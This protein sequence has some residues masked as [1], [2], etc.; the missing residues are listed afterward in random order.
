MTV[1][2][3]PE[4]VAEPNLDGLFIAGGISGCPDWQSVITRDL[5]A[6]GVP[7]PMYNPRRAVYST[8]PGV[9]EVQIAWEFDALN[10]S[11]AVIFWFPEETLCPITLFE[12]GRFSHQKDTQLFVGTHPNYQRKLDV[13][14]QLQ[15]ARP[16]IAV[17]E[18]LDALTEQVSNY[19]TES[20]VNNVY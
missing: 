6:A 18:S 4:P 3:A 10:K 13:V 1:I 2:T 20:K 5:E 14:T 15:L 8:A 12:L 19:Y 17:V 7:V 11:S 9:A 16:E